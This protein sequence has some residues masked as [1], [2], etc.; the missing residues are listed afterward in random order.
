MVLIKE[1]SDIFTTNGPSHVVDEAAEIGKL[2]LMNK[3]FK[4][5]IIILYTT[6]TRRSDLLNEFEDL[7]QAIEN[8][9]DPGVILILSTTTVSVR[10]Q[11]E[12][13]YLGLHRYLEFWT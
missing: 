9:T 11:N 1:S 8:P 2:A 7:R 13:L 12:D 10:V 6:Q 5:T 4:N 3:Q